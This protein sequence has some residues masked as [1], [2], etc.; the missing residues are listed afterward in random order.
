MKPI[1]ILFGM[2]YL[3][4][5]DLNEFSQEKL[6]LITNTIAHACVTTQG[7]LRHRLMDLHLKCMKKLLQKEAS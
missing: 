2:D 1:D 4:K 6:E 5:S 7:S 3:E